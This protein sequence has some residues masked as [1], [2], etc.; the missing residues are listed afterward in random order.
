MLDIQNGVIELAHG[1]GGR[2][3]NRLLDELI[4]AAFANPVL[5]E[6]SDQ[7]QLDLPP[8]RVV[9]AT[10]SHVITPLFY[11]G[12]N[13]G[14]L[15]VHGTINDVVMSGARPLYLSVGLIIEAGFPLASLKRILDEMAIAAKTSGVQIVTGDTKVVEKGDADGIYINT[16]GI[17]VV[18]HGCYLSATHIQPGDKIIISG[19]LGDHGATVLAQRQQLKVSGD[20]KSDSQALDGLVQAMLPLVGHI[21]CMRDPTRGGLAATLNELAQAAGIG[22]L[23]DET[24][25][26]VSPAVEALCEMLGLDPLYLANE[27]KL[28]TFVAPNYA[29]ELL[30]MMQTHPQGQQAQIIGQVQEDAQRFVEMQTSYGGKRLVDWRYADPLPRIC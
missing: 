30:K 25:L 16:T 19:T 7:A 21:R 18:E 27:G 6:K 11:P 13:I 5:N 4:L 2:A 28:V 15:A 14:S 1:A 26:P 9:M 29:D 17:G 3:M 8:G 22:I 12:G 20:L 24:Q 23:L 10:D